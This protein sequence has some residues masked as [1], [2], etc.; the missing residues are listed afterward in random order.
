[1]K[2]M[3]HD[4]AGGWNRVYL[5]LMIL[6]TLF[7]WAFFGGAITRM[8]AVQLARNEKISLREAIVFARARWQSYFS[9]P[10]IPLIF[11]GILTVI[12][13]IFGIFAGLIPILGDIA[14]AGLLWPIVL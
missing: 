8:A 5:I 12:L 4:G 7:V 9:A 10:L 13:I 11:L 3:F 14:I 6:W 1:I 2:Y